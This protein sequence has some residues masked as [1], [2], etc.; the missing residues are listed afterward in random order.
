MLYFFLFYWNEGFGVKD[1]LL[2]PLSKRSLKENKKEPLLPKQFY[3]RI[4]YLK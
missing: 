3:D 4:N 2:F 1:Y